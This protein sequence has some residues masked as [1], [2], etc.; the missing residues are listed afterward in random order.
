MK[1]LGVSIVNPNESQVEHL[2]KH[3]LNGAFHEL[4]A[5]S[6]GPHWPPNSQTKCCTVFMFN[7]NSKYK[8]KN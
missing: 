2:R 8:L 4:A 3:L 6:L 1:M 5:S 7:K